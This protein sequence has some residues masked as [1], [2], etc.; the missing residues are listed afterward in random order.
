MRQKDSFSS[1]HPLVNFIY[2]AAVIAFSMFFTHPLFLLTSFF[3]S[4]AFY[5]LLEGSAAKNF[6]LWFAL[7]LIF[8]T[9]M[10][11]PLLSHEGQ[12][13]LF[14]LPSGNPLTLESVLYG[15][16]AGVMLAT[17]MLWFF[18]FSKVMTS[19]KFVYLFSRFSPSLSLL[20]SMT[21]RFIPQ[22]R[23]QFQT[24][25]EL[26]LSFSGE[27]KSLIKK[28]KTA[29]SCF[30]TVISWSLENAVETADSMKS[31][32]YGTAKR[33]SYTAYR[34]SQRD[35][36][37]LF[38]LAFCVFVIVCGSLYGSIS[39]RYYPTVKGV[40]FQPLTLFAL[41]IYFAM[42]V[43]PVFLAWKEAL[44]WKHLKSEI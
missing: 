23:R 43:M 14:Y 5:I 31:R 40:L 30:V 26:Q 3:S 42:C 24:V 29:V 39:W 38:F 32:G 34:V 11:N 27:S 33:T 21:L 6:I 22:F 28:I 41:L 16:G 8:I 35:K 2:F 10:M 19:D 44:E 12:T 1:Y 9:A 18:C 7:P 15:I 4:A 17:V 13:I 25:S 36:Y 37:A 20:L